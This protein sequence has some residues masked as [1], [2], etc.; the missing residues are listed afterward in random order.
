MDKS[1]GVMESFIRGVPSN[2]K[3]TMPLK[4][5][6]VASWRAKVGQIN[7]ADG[8]THYSVAVSSPLNILGIVNNG[9]RTD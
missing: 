4:G 6:N 8:Y 7:M 2:G 1:N 9:D 3:K 5:E